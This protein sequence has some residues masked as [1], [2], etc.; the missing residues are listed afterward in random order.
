MQNIK[1]IGLTKTTHAELSELTSN[2][3]ST[4]ETQLPQNS[5]LMDIVAFIRPKLSNL[6]AALAAIRIN[7]LV[8]E[9]FELDQIR[10]NAFIVFR[11]M[12]QAYEKTDDP[13]E[14]E[15][16]KQ[17]WAV[18]E[19]TG[20]R[21]Y[22]EGYIEQSGRLK[23]LFSEM[24]K[25]DKK[26]AI[27][28]LGI[29]QRYEKLKIAEQNFKKTYN[30]RLEEDARKNYPTVKKSRAALTPLVNDLIPVLRYIVRT[31]DKDTDLSWAALINE[32]TD[33]VMAQV[34]ARRT[35]KE[36]GEEEE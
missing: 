32:Q 10:D 9:A 16:Y 7:S 34:A 33:K 22:G 35:R 30:E 2:Y 11:D 6:Y 3:L 19:K 31:A 23:T 5:F 13:K 15:A 17:L 36:N 20:T 28:T 26:A 29:E 18:I 1:N 14:Q 4:I 27:A 12:I 24:D 25:A 21:L 8:E